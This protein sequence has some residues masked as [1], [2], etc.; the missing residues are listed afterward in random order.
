MR[1]RLY[2]H[3]NDFVLKL[4]PVGTTLKNGLIAYWELEEASGS[5]LDSHTNGLTL[6]ESGTVPQVA[7]KVG[8][9]AH[10]TTAGNFL[11]RAD[12][13]LF[14]FSLGMSVAA[15]V[16]FP[17]SVPSGDFLLVSRAR[18]DNEW[19]LM[20]LNS[21]SRFFFQTFDAV[22]GSSQI[23]A[24]TF[25]APSADIYYLVVATADN[26]N[27]KISVNAGTQD[28]VAQSGVIANTAEFFRIGEQDFNAGFHG[29]QCGL[30]NRALTASE[31]TQLYN[32]GSGLAYSSL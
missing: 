7:G 12:D 13:A 9:A 27:I 19:R 15:W 23:K 17:T 10:L 6:T 29:D 16:R 25:G 32:A 24:D 8:N 11:S 26:T 28:S 31:I 21:D 22:A 1:R 14:D 18:S 30:W 5:R 20:W 2:V 3:S 4:P